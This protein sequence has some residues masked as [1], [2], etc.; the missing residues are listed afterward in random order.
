[1]IAAPE[2]DITAGED[3]GDVEFDAV[4][5]VRPQVTVA[6][7][8]ALRIEIPNPDVTDEAVDTQVD[9]LRDRFADLEDSSGTL[10]D[11]D[12]AEIDIKGYVHEESIEGLTATDYLYEVGSGMVVP[13]L[14]EELRGKRPGDILKFNDTLPERFAER[15]GDEVAFQVLVKETKRKVLPEVTDEWVA[16]ISEFDSVDALRDDMRTRLDLYARMQAQLIV[17]D[18]VLVAASDLV[19]GEIPDTLVNQEM[20]RRLHDLAHRLEEQMPGVTIP[21]YLA[22]SGQDQQEFVDGVREGAVGAVRADLALRS[23]VAEEGIEA[24]DEEVDAEVDRLAEQLG[25]KPAKVRKDLERRGVIQAVRSDIER[26]KALAFLIEHATVVDED[27]NP[28]D[29]SPPEP[30][31]AQPTPETTAEAPAEEPE[32]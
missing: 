3:D 4:V 13:K 12:Y 5:E 25:E 9:M 17:R 14:D 23:V 15:A 8:D 24:S 21:Q 16:E 32:S 18:K 2:I 30:E 19:T 6:G 29:L 31:D 28:V 26:S 11:G 20:E 22:A 1:M 10:N 27:G 7:H